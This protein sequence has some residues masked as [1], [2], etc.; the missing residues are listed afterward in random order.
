V[1]LAPP[2]HGSPGHFQNTSCIFTSSIVT[3]TYPPTSTKYN[4]GKGPMGHSGR[5]RENKKEGK[6]RAGRGDKTV[7]P[8]GEEGRGNECEDGHS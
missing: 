3:A 5:R 1:T 4:Q 6:C 7:D 8:Y 2:C